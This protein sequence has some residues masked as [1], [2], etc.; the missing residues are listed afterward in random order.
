MAAT[1]I[2][3]VDDEKAF[4]SV[5]ADRLKAR[6][7]VVDTV[8]SGEAALKKVVETSYDAIVL[9]LIMPKLDG[10]ATLKRLLDINPDLQI[11][12]LTGQATLDK[13]IEALKQGAME[14]LEKPADIETLVEKVRQAE[15]KKRLLFEHRMEDLISRITQERG[16]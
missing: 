13:G 16:W 3:I 6:G 15:A 8:E 11:I 10:I 14:F 5:L 7:F 9:D 4:S 1:R 12:L 2:L